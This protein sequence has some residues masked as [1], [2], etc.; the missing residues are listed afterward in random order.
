MFPRRYIQH[1]I[2]ISRLRQVSG[3][4]QVNGRRDERK[5]VDSLRNKS[6]TLKQLQ[7]MKAAWSAECPARH[8]PLK[9]IVY[10]SRLLGNLEMSFETQAAPNAITRIEGKLEPGE[11]GVTSKNTGHI[12]SLNLCSV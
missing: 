2:K 8:P 1:I 11:D 12:S 4:D 7:I 10:S 9:P 3:A 5:K 6:L